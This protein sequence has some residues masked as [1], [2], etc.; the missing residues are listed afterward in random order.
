MAHRV[1]KLKCIASWLLLLAP[2]VLLGIMWWIV[3]A[4]A[5][6][7][8]YDAGLQ[9][10]LAHTSGK[11]SAILAEMQVRFQ[12]D[13]IRL[14][15]VTYLIES[16]WIPRPIMAVILAA[17][18]RGCILLMMRLSGSNMRRPLDVA[19]LSFCLT[20]TLQW[21]Y[22]P[23]SHDFALNYLPTLL[24]AL[25]IC[26]LFVRLPQLSRTG[27]FA[28]FSL[29]L[30]SGFW[31]EGCALTLLCALP[32]Y[33]LARRYIGSAAWL[34]CLLLIPGVVLYVLTPGF[35]ARMNDVVRANA[36]IMLDPP[37]LLSLSVIPVVLCLFVHDVRKYGYKGIPQ[38]TAIACMGVGASMASVILCMVSGW[39]TRAGLVGV[40][41]TLPAWIIVLNRLIPSIWINRLWPAAFLPL[42]IIVCNLSLIIFE[43]RD[44]LKVYNRAI[45]QYAQSEQTAIFCDTKAPEPHLLLWRYGH[46]ARKFFRRSLEQMRICQY[47]H[48]VVRQTIFFPEELR[49]VDIRPGS[50][51]PG[52]NPLYEK[53][54]F[55]YIPVADTVPE[56]LDY[57]QWNTPSG[58]IEAEADTFRTP[59]T[60]RQ[61][62]Y[63]MPF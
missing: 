33:M 5:D 18:F 21:L 42:F 45:E 54:G 40:W 31:H 37:Y 10:A 14:A 52:D 62:L 2:A 63:V 15:N 29:A 57:F 58:I 59:A 19:F 36:A 28:L 46:P 9:N 61:Y 49:E 23:F 12:M 60:G 6:D 24:L 47:R 3:P 32:A 38:Q 39:I 43:T 51:V 4:N 34:A 13:N 17:C 20:F 11:W 22:F 7:L 56:N 41:L 16:A 25:G 44:F 8:W 1:E 48:G 27:R 53:A 30:L 50:K 55:L 26:T 35:T